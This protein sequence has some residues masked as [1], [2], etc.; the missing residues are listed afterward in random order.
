MKLFW[1]LL[2]IVN[3]NCFSQVQKTLP[4]RTIQIDDGLLN[5]SYLYGGKTVNSL[6][7]QIPLQE[8]NDFEVNKFYKQNQNYNRLSSATSF[9]PLVYLYTKDFKSINGRDFTF[10]FISTIVS[11]NI[12]KAI[13]RKKLKK[14][15]FRY[16]NLIIR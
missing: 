16:N 3:L 8:V 13:G 7:L 15:I 11:N 4:L 5:S 10:V 14:A 6:A 2:F 1:F 9:I 12:L